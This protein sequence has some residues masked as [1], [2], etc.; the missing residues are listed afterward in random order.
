MQRDIGN[1]F[2]V[3][4]IAV[5]VLAF[6]VAFAII[7]SLSGGAG[8]AA[9]PSRPAATEVVAQ[10]GTT[11]AVTQEA[12][13]QPTDVPSSTLPAL[14]DIVPTSATQVAVV[15]TLVDTAAPVPATPTDTLTAPTATVTMTDTAFPTQSVKAPNTL[16]PATSTA[17]E[18][19][20]SPTP[21][22]TVTSTTTLT[23]T[24]RPTQSPV[25][26]FTRIPPSATVRPSATPLP[27]LTNTARP[28][29]TPL[30]TKTA[31]PRPSPTNTPKPTLT[32]TPKP[33]STPLPTITPTYTATTVPTQFIAP[34]AT[35]GCTP[36]A[37]WVAYSIQ[38]NDTLLKIAEKTG[39]TL[40]GLQTANCLSNLNTLYIG[41]NLFVPHLPSA[42]VSTSFTAEGCTD[43]STTL[44]KP[45]LGELISGVVTVEGTAN[46]NNFALYK[47]EIRP[48]SG[49][50]YTLYNTYTTPV[51]QGALG[52]I[53]TRIFSPGIYW[54]KLTVFT[55]DN[56][57]MPS[58]AIPVLFGQ[59]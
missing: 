5:G 57:T 59:S 30:P 58:C 33:T 46:A 8:Q 13:L 21:L 38:R 19:V 15:I 42:T 49:N 14:T 25:A 7:L 41:Q 23:A 11:D 39:T 10:V 28:S 37:N 20:A 51:S 50:V 3:A 53:D 9:T 22:P 44:T 43:T 55:Q 52:Q 56:K 1:E 16:I 48:G 31:T 54:I 4:I 29:Q 34:T 18:K 27:T 32:N 45:T 24:P 12:S 35:L 47:L 17:T 26:T 6:A 40:E 2:I 36:P